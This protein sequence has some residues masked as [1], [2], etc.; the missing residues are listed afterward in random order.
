M[1]A[2]AILALGPAPAVSAAGYESFESRSST[3][4]LLLYDV[5]FEHR[6]GPEGAARFERDVLRSLEDAHRELTRRLDLTPRREIDVVI[7]NPSNFDRAV[8]GRVRFPTAGFYRERIHVRGDG[9]MTPFMEAVLAHELVHAVLDQLA[10]SAG[11]PA[12]VHEGLASWFEARFAGRRGLSPDEWRALG[13]AAAG[14][15]WLGLDRLRVASFQGLRPVSASRAY[16]QSQALFE[17]LE[18]RRGERAL[19]EFANRLVRTGDA[20]RSL[21]R[22]AGMDLDELDRSLRGTLLRP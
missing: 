21:E 19:R 7:H 8:A 15:R 4:F 13:A 5:P 11:I 16:R 2:L 20:E 17:H 9:R 6:T 18:D 14:G 3:H 10:P 1:V 12:W 22:T